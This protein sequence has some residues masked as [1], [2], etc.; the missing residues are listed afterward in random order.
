MA[1]RTTGE[2]VRKIVPTVGD[3]DITPFLDVATALVDKVS[4]EDSG[5]LLN[6]SLLLQMEKWLAAHFYAI[7]DPQYSEKRE[8]NAEAKFQGKTA[9][10]LDS[11]LWGQMAKRID[12]TGYLAALDKGGGRIG[13]TWLGLPPSEQTNYVDRD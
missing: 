1:L 3:N 11:T 7:Y 8:E 5:G 2:A 9:M 13:I 10:G 6:A 12:V 4:A